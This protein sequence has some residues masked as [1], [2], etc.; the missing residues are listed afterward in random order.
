GFNPTKMRSR[1][2]SGT[3]L[4][5]EQ[6]MHEYMEKNAAFNAIKGNDDYLQATMKN[7]GGG[8]SE[9]DWR[10]YLSA[11]GYSGR[12]LEQ[13]VAAI[14]AARRGTS[15]DVFKQSAVMANASTGT[16]WKD[17]GVAE[18]MESINEASGGD[19]HLATNMLVAKC[20]SPP[21]ASLIDSIISAT[22]PSFQPVPVLALAIT[23]DCLKTSWL[24]PRRAARMA[25]TPC[26]R[27]LPE[28][29]C[30]DR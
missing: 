30:A 29:P 15:Q 12:D 23:A 2:Q 21:E 11:H 22:P 8:D 10:N 19:R 27:S 4:A 16:G 7:M 13:G 20:R 24:V 6:E 18:M 25:A 1:F 3:S 28:Y 9:D 17:G 5:K 14:R 26:S